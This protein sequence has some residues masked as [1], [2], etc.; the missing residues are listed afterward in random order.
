MQLLAGRNGD[1]VVWRVEGEA[2]RG[3]EVHRVGSEGDVQL[4]G[5]VTIL[6]RC[7]ADVRME[8]VGVDTVGGIKA[9]SGISM[10]S[11]VVSQLGF[12]VIH[13]ILRNKATLRKVVRRIES[14]R[15]TIWDRCD[16]STSIIIGSS[17]VPDH[18]TCILTVIPPFSGSK[19]HLDPGQKR[20]KRSFE[21]DHRLWTLSVSYC[22]NP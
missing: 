11:E 17:T 20:K 21:W 1:R 7:L 16:G 9:S 2:S 22:W 8:V 15:G 3:T 19:T 18:N 14:K 5:R 10:V 4:H 6:K 13:S 12:V